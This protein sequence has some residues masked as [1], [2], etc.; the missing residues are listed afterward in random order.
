M[1]S[2]FAT[3]FWP[4]DLLPGDQRPPEGAG[5]EAM[6]QFRERINSACTTVRSATVTWIEHGAALSTLA[7][8]ADPGD[9]VGA[10]MV[11]TFVHDR[12][13]LVLPGSDRAYQPTGKDLVLNVSDAVGIDSDGMITDR[14]S[15]LSFA[16]LH[17]QLETTPRADPTQRSANQHQ[18]CVAEGSHLEIMRRWRC[19][20]VDSETG[21]PRRWCIW[22]V[23]GIQ[24]WSAGRKGARLSSAR[25][26]RLQLPV[27]CRR[28]RRQRRARPGRRDP[29]AQPSTAPVPRCPRLDR[30]QGRPPPPGQGPR[31]AGAVPADRRGG[32]PGLTRR[33][34]GARRGGGLP[35]DAVRIGHLDGDYYDPRCTW[36][37]HHQIASDNAV[38]VR[39]DRFIAWRHPAGTG[40]PR[41]ALAAALSQILARPVGRVAS[42]ARP[43]PLSQQ[44]PSGPL[45]GVP[46]HPPARP[47]RWP[48]PAP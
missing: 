37:R 2:R 8:G 28:A 4:H 47:W 16:R 14:W 17:W 31:R 12:G 18:L 27:R 21:S 46:H 42:P 22:R 5:I 30:R 15:G 10:S 43:R 38:L 35:L 6:E 48:R 20:A 7:G 36:Q 1:K 3:S 25:R 23:I 24:G 13:P 44:P 19:P 26:I 33:G 40:D 39:P 9:L 29:R 41:G 32:R 34:Q 45:A 11:V